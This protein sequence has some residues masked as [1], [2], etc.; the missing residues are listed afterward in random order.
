VEQLC[1][2]VFNPGDGRLVAEVLRGVEAERRRR[3]G[4]EAPS[5]RY[6]V[7]LFA[8]AGRVD[9]AADGLESLL[10]PERQV[11]EED[12]FTLAANK[13]L[14]PKLGFAQNSP[15]DVLKAPERYPAHVSLL[16]E[17]FAVLGSVRKIDGLRRGS[18]VGGLVQE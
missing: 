4:A 7:H 17:Q 8:G 12:E 9:A 3:L 16:L 15:A 18:F 1:L 14:L 10:D 11:G 13:H 5:I 6:A 2:N